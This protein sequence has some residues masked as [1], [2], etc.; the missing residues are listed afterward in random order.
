[1]KS[2]F[3]KIRIN[4]QSWTKIFKKIP[5]KIKQ[6]FLNMKNI[7]LRSMIEKCSRPSLSLVHVSMICTFF[8]ECFA[9]QSHL[10][11]LNS[12][13]WFG[14]RHFLGVSVVVVTVILL[15]R[16][17]IS[18]LDAG[19]SL[20]SCESSIRIGIGL[21]CTTLFSM[22]RHSVWFSKENSSISVFLPTVTYY[23]IV[24]YQ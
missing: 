7:H 18:T 15:K 16:S 14:H 11:P 17:T 10:Q 2:E 1:M 6:F 19:S 24:I 4:F 13:K 8:V 12:V 3:K 21:A 22:H 9:M 20:E 23:I 5:K